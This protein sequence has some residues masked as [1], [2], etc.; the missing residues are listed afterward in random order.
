MMPFCVGVDRLLDVGGAALP[1]IRLQRALH[2]EQH[3]IAHA[4]PFDRPAH[5]LVSS[6]RLLAPEIDGGEDRLRIRNDPF[7]AGIAVPRDE[8]AQHRGAVLRDEAFAG[9]GR[10]IDA[11][12][13]AAA[14]R[15]AGRVVALSRRRRQVDDAE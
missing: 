3:D 10:A 6:G 7:D 5:R 8:H 9:R 4:Q 2:F 15:D 13:R 14:H 12:G 1:G 11:R